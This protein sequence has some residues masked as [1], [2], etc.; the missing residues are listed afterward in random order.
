MGDDMCVGNDSRSNER[1]RTVNDPYFTAVEHLEGLG[2]SRWTADRIAMMQKPL[3]RECSVEEHV[4]LIIR[5]DAEQI[6]DLFGA[7]L[8]HEA[9]AWKAEILGGQA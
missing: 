3:G 9:R 8:P 2:F 5:C 4:A 7:M 6:K 1:N